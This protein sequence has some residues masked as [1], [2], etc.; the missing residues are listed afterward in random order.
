MKIFSGTSNKPLAQKI[1]KN[2]GLPLSDLEI[3]VFPD[4]EKRVRALD[5]VVGEDCVVVQPTSPEPDKNYMELFLIADAI[6]RNGAKSITAVIPYLSYQRQ[7]RLFREGEAVSLD[8]IRKI[9]EAVGISKIITIDLHSVRIPELFKIEVAHL[10]ALSIFAEKILE[11][12]RGSV[13]DCVLVS[14]DMG[15]VRRIKILSE[16]L[17]GMPYAVIVKNRNLATGKLTASEIQ[18]EIKKRAIIVDDMIS[19]GETIKLATELLRKNGAKEIYVFA[20]HPVFSKDAKNVLQKS[21]AE[22]VFVT[23]TIEIPKE[24]E[25]PKLEILSVSEM[26]AGQLKK[27]S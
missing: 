25:F 19:T 18:G 17:G 12:I 26:I 10:S 13:A 21:Y 9:L 14:P 1:A 22:R 2:L 16:M 23:D 27:N 6:L 15:G 4:G 20:T 3:F 11:I 24:K 8:V 5:K 7:D